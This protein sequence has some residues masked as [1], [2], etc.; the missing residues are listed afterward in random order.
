M[1]V[2]KNLK[3]K[4]FLDISKVDIRELPLAVLIQKGEK[5]AIYRVDKNDEKNFYVYFNGKEIPPI[6]DITE[7]AQKFG[8]KISRSY[9]LKA[10]VFPVE[11]G[12]E[13]KNKR[14]EIYRAVF[15]P[16]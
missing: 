8:E 9:F 2:M 11:T 14:Y 4:N 15:S 13:I 6:K 1:N 7:A 12:P 5:T 3:P 10:S 16:K